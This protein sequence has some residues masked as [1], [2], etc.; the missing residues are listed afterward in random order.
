MRCEEGEPTSGRIQEIEGL[1]TVA[2]TL[3]AVYHVWFNRVSGGVDVFLFISAYLITR[4]FLRRGGR[5]F[6]PVTFLV[7]RFA[8]LLP[9]AT[10]T[11]VITLVASMMVFP[12]WR[13]PAFFESAWMSLTYRQ[14]LL[15]QERHVDYF[16]IDINIL[17]PYQHF[18]SLSAQGQVFILWALLHFAVLV[19]TRVTKLRAEWFLGL[20][21][22]LLFAVSL[23]FAQWQTQ[24]AQTLAYFDTRA[25]LWEFSLGSLLALVGSVAIPAL[26]RQLMILGG[27]A[28]LVACGFLIDVQGAFP[29]AVALVPLGAAGAI[30][31]AGTAKGTVRNPLRLPLLAA[32][33]KY[34]YALYLVHWPILVMAQVIVGRESLNWWQ[35]AVTLGLSALVSVTLVHAIEQ[36]V[37]GWQTRANARHAVLRAATVVLVCL[38]IGGAA[39]IGSR[40]LTRTQVE[41]DT[42]YRATKDWAT[43]EERC[44]RAEARC[45][46]RGDESDTSGRVAFVGNSHMQQ[47]MPAFAEAFSGWSVEAHLLPGC[48]YRESGKEGTREVTCA[49]LWADVVDG[50]VAGDAEVVVALATVSTVEGADHPVQGLKRWVETVEAS[51]RDVVLIRDNPRFLQNIFACGQQFGLHDERCIEPLAQQWLEP[52]DMAEVLPVVDVTKD[53]CPDGVCRP[54]TSDGR[55]VYLDN[56]HITASF[57]RSL[58]PSVSAQVKDLRGP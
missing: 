58:G 44:D 55:L 31:V 7:K 35:G 42:G 14:N 32:A 52:A 24:N 40:T 10:A 34:T 49:Q 12:M 9:L 1:R 48:H 26:L 13:W 36:P 15:L 23:A 38:A 18:W 4:S 11:I 46:P 16:G 17:S 6:N 21:F 2:L 45:V 41:H 37:A 20:G 3:V 47:Y 19:A 43:V 39:V 25:R 53:I 30:I 27:L 54:A 22:G 28:V 57:S 5:G 8:R 51:G 33:G 29:G 56:N 50:A